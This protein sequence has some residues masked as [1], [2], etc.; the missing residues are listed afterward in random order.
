MQLKGT[1]L[2]DMTEWL[3]TLYYR[4]ADFI[5]ARIP[6]PI[7]PDEVLAS[8]RIISHRGEHDNRTTFE[9]TL[10]AFDRAVAGGVWGL[11]CDLRWTKDLQ[12]VIIHDPDT[13]RVFGQRETIS[14]LTLDEVRARVPQIPTLQEVLARYS[15]KTHLMIELKTEPYP[16]PAG[17][18]RTLR[19]LTADLQPV[20]DYH[21]IAFQPGLFACF[22]FLPSQTF[23]P[24][25]QLN[26]FHLSKLAVR[27]YWGGVLGH[28]TMLGKGVISVQKNHDQHLGTGFIESRNCLFQELNRGIDWIFSNTATE[29]QTYCVIDKDT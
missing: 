29:L 17:Q 19:N 5:S 13:R 22:D 20:T 12:P 1:D 16:D 11:E 2:T 28:Y 24:I 26:T 6:R 9:N 8:A 27:N 18:A 25:A 21:L 14:R 7:P 15:G 3:R 23:L 10:P 4:S